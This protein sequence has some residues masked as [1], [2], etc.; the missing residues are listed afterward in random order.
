MAGLLRSIARSYVRHSPLEKGKYHLVQA[1]RRIDPPA[2]VVTQVAGR[3]LMDLD[4]SE[5]L[6]GILYYYGYYER[7]LTRFMEETIRPGS[8]MVDVGGAFGSVSLLADFWEPPA[9][10]LRP[11]RI[12]ARRCAGILPSINSLVSRFTNVLSQTTREKPRFT[13]MK[14]QGRGIRAG[15]MRCSGVELGGKSW[16]RWRLSP[17]APLVTSN[18]PGVPDPLL[19]VIR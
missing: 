17:T 18:T 8:L 15:R 4:L 5:S 10:H 6:Q 2:K 12:T 19:T 14:K 9:T 13:Y 16:Y 1:M 11:P 3:F 7:G